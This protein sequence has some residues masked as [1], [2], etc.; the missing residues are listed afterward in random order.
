M[1]EE[2]EARLLRIECV[3]PLELIFGGRRVLKGEEVLLADLVLLVEVFLGGRDA[4][5][6]VDLLR[7]ELPLS[8]E[9]PFP[10]R[11]ALLREDTDVTLVLLLI[12]SVLSFEELFPGRDV[13]LGGEMTLV[14]LR[15]ELVLSLEEFLGGILVTLALLL[16]ILG[17]RRGDSSDFL[18]S[19][20]PDRCFLIFLAEEEEIEWDFPGKEECISC[21]SF[22]RSSIAPTRE[23]RD[24]CLDESSNAGLCC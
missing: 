22:D 3:L 11:E 8:V 16:L 18:L 7:I 21:W 23:G 9:E 4:L 1:L 17:S 5:E 20:V 2:T 10:G 24:S 6:D 12:E 13:L 14:L 15:I 19:P